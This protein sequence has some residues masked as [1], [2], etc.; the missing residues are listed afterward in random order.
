LKNDPTL[1]IRRAVRADTDTLVR[2]NLAMAEETEG[3]TLS[4]SVLGAGVRSVFDDP[5]KGF[6]V[7]AE[8]AGKPVGGL[9]VTPEWSDWRNAYYWWI[10]SVYVEPASRRHGVYTRLHRYVESAAKSALDVCGI[11]LYVDGNNAAARS[12]YERMGMARSRYDFFENVEQA[13]A[14]PGES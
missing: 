13:G 4:P 9:L 2:F 1:T 5:S 7:I 11:R 3:K 12:V 14:E 6:Y 10:Q 8:A